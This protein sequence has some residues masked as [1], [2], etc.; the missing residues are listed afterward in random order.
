MRIIKR[1][2]EFYVQVY[3]NERQEMLHG[4][5]LVQPAKAL[6]FIKTGFSHLQP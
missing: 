3:L 5:E 1:L 4:E 6:V 2:Y